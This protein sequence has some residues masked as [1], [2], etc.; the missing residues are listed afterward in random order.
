MDQQQAV[1]QNILTRRSVRKYQ[2]KPIP[3]DVL[4]KIL[5]AGFWAPSASN[6]QTWHFTVMTNKDTIDKWNEAGKQWMAHCGRESQQRIGRDP[7]RHVFFH[8]PCVLLVSYKK[9][10]SWHSNW[11]EVDTALAA[12]NIM[13]AAHAMGL[14]SCYIGWFTP[15]LKSGAAGELLRDMPLPEYYQPFHFITL[16]YPEQVGPAP[17]RIGGYIDYLDD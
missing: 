11:G 13:L 3:H 4:E 5:E 14:G 2:Q 12:E 7:E 16:G 8:A 15:W 9:D 17:R 6:R 1:L 10:P